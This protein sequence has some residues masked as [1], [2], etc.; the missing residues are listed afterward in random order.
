MVAKSTLIGIVAG[1][2]ALVGGFLLEGGH[3]E[4]LIEYTAII[5]VFGGTFAAVAVSFPWSKLR[6]LPDAIRYAFSNP[7]DEPA[8]LIDDLTEMAN[9]A[10]RSGVLALERAAASH[11][12]QFLQDGLLM[13]VDGTDPELTRQI[14]E[15]EVDAMERKREMQ[16]KI[17]EAAGGYAPTMGIVGTV[18]GL[19]HVLGSLTDPSAL[20]PAIAVAFTATLYGVASANIIYLPIASKI[21]SRNEDEVLLQEM[22]IEGILSIQAGHNSLLL[23]KKLE[24]LIH[25]PSSQPAK[26][27]GANE[28]PQPTQ[29]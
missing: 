10:R 22:L 3:I 4:G 20:G 6:S 11:Q 2:L 1:L 27:E 15:T 26:K 25:M 5:I 9:T 18:M 17:L 14:L 28:P 16:A 21:R 24:A 19:I 13:I 7:Q 29:P 8:R 23:R 12:N